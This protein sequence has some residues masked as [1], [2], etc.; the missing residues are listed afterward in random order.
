MAPHP[1]LVVE[2]PVRIRPCRESDLEALEWFGMFTAHRKLIRDAWERHLAGDNVM[3][4]AEA[5]RFPVGQVWIDL[6]RHGDE[7]AGLLWAVRVFPLL[8]GLGIGGRLL[9]AAEETLADRGYR[10]ALIGVEKHNEGA[11][12]LYRRRGY[13]PWSELRESY[14]Y[15]PPGSDVPIEIEIDEWLLRK[16]VA[17]VS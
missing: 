2:L 1:P 11:Y 8:Q 5:N 6:A 16:R 4:V 13:A 17:G 7:S 12:R 15:V 3:L 10:W 9:D 14:A